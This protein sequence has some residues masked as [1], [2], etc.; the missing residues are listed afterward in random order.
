MQTQSLFIHKNLSLQSCFLVEAARVERKDSI[1]KSLLW[2]MRHLIE[3]QSSIYPC[4]LLQI[5]RQTVLSLWISSPRHFPVVLMK[6][7][8]S[9]FTRESKV[10]SSGV[11]VDVLLWLLFT[12]LLCW[13]RCKA[14]KK[15][16]SDCSR[17]SATFP[18]TLSSSYRCFIPPSSSRLLSS[19]SD[20]CSAACFSSMKGKSRVLSAITEIAPLRYRC[21]PRCTPSYFLPAPF[22]TLFFSFQFCYF[23]LQ[24]F[25]A[26]E[27]ACQK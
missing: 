24:V 7:F 4:L 3:Q 23:F 2:S 17:S 14:E 10:P 22:C 8:N 26:R 21:P 12:A 15:F 19:W 20:F 16:P 27:V 11:R 18:Y 13:S 1:A 5:S 25:L 9:G 6:F